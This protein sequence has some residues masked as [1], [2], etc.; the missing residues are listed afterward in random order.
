MKTNSL[1]IAV[2]LS[3]AWIITI[4][5]GQSKQDN[6]PR[7]PGARSV[8]RAAEYASL[9]EAFDALPESGGW[10]RRRRRSRRVRCD[11]DEVWGPDLTTRIFVERYFSTSKPVILRG[12]P[13]SRP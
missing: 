13:K 4:S 9:Q 1:C 11:L 8:I 6:A 3:L 12:T 2:T 5:F 10:L 7:L